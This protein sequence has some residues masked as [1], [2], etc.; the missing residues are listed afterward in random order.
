MVLVGRWAFQWD[1]SSN[2][3]QQYILCECC[4]AFFDKV[5]KNG[6]A[7]LLEAAERG[8]RDMKKNVVQ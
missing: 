2:I 3:S 5:V 1:E 7:K 4:N 8:D 6:D